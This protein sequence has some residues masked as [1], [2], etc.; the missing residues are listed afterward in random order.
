MRKQ[1]ATGLIK[2]LCAIGL[3]TALSACNTIHGAGQDIEKGGE[4]IQQKADEHS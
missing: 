3:L 1:L 2:T 4:K